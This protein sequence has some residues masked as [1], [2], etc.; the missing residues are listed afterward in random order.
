MCSSTRTRRGG[1]GGWRA[2]SMRRGSVRAA[3][4]AAGAA[5]AAGACGRRRGAARVTRVFLVDDQSLVRAGLRMVIDSQPD[6]TVVG[7]A[8]DGREALDRIAVTTADVVLMDVRMPRLDDSRLAALSDR[9]RAIL[10]EV[11]RG[12]SNAEIATVLHIAEPTVKTYLG[13]L[14][15]KLD[16]HDRVQLVIFAY[17]SGLVAPRR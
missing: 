9:E 13:R 15:A 6:M 10:L 12:R 14:R 1:G 7:E 17:D 3:T 5:P 11:A 2:S 4:K 16:L 8:E